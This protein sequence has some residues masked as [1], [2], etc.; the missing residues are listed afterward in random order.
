MLRVAGVRALTCSSNQ[1]LSTQAL[2]CG[3]LALQIFGLAKTRAKLYMIKVALIGP[4][5]HSEGSLQQNDPDLPN[6]SGH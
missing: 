5:F 6:L 1:S 4:G 2:I 3:Q